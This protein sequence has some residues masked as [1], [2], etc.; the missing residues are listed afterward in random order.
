MVYR[1]ITVAFI[2]GVW[3]SLRS[4]PGGCGPKI[5][6]TVTMLAKSSP[7]TEYSAEVDAIRKN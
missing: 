5:S 6:V 1:A 4:I 7:F 2:W 3:L